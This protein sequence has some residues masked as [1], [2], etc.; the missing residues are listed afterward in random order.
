[1]KHK[2]KILIT[3][4]LGY[5]G[6]V[7]ST[8][9]INRGFS[10]NGYD[11]GYFKECKFNFHKSHKIS[12]VIKDIRDVTYKDLKDVNIV[13]HLAGLSNDPLGELAKEVTNEINYKGTV[14]IAKL[15]KKAGVQRFIFTS[16]QSIYGISKLNKELDEYKSV[17][18]PITQ[19]AKS[20]MKAEKFLLKINSSKFCVVIF[21]P[22][23]VFGASNRF[24]SDIVFNNLMA[25]GF[26]KNKIVIN[27]DGKPWRPV[28]HVK[29]VCNAIYAGMIAPLNKV[30]GQIYNL[31]IYGGNYT[32]KQIALNAKKAM[33]NCNLKINNDHKDPRS[34]KVS[35]NKIYNELKPYYKPKYTLK[36]G[37][38]EII[39]FFKKI[40]FTKNHFEG[41]KTNRLMR[42][43]YL[44]K[45]RKINKKLK[46]KKKI[47][48]A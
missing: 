2:K 4:N 20:K 31:G 33:K 12:Q 17:K 5:I 39:N 14:K 34:Y 42:L 15:A 30:N 25:S 24:R 37:G 6:S 27:T 32:V 44:M 22:S 48:Y 28:I 18:N 41:Q 36:Y 11:I 10:I 21:R 1:M 43:K 45:T 8:Y 46:F 23:T 26:T 16:S 47:S 13:I 38:K 9:L 3:G 19:Y 7:L 40:R 29:D 35:F